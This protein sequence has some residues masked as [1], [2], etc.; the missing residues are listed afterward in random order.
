MNKKQIGLIFIILFIYIAIAP[1]TVS[2][3]AV[4]MKASLPESVVSTFGKNPETGRNFTWITPL[5]TKNG[6]VEYCVKDKFKGFDKVNIQ[7]A[8]AKSYKTNTDND[9]RIIHKVELVNLKPGTEYVYRVGIKGY[10]S[11]QGVFRTAAKDLTSFTF[12]NITDTQGTSISDYKVWKGTLD[13]ALEKFP[14][15]RF[16]IHTGDMVDNG[17][18]IGQWDNFTEVARKELIKLPIVPV[19]GNHEMLNSNKTNN[20]AKNYTDRFDTPQVQ[21]TGAPLGTVYSFDYGNA[22]IA[23]MNTQCGGNNLKSQGEWLRND[24]AKSLKKWKIV[25]LHRGPY[26]AT[27][28][29]T[30]IRKAWVPIFDELGIDLVLQGHDHNYMRSYPMKNGVA[31]KPG[32]GTIYMVGNTGGVKFYPLKSRS[33]QA[34]DLQPRV[35]M[36]IS[37]T[38]SSTKMVIRAYDNKNKLRDSFIVNK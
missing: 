18:D 2:P 34:V 28:D 13:K 29:T 37:V 1:F 36:Y 23:V 15:A 20:N 32:K 21:G 5:D 24:M 9:T 22:H 14:D 30:D 33:W 4:T 10:Y 16:L 3:E 12:I 7:S 27:Y 19:V 38:V 31:V 6:V 35:P 17:Q 26:G 8:T 25:A 11:E